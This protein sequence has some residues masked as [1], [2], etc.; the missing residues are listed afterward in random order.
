MTT[1]QGLL[2]AT[3]FYVGQVFGVRGKQEHANLQ[4]DQ[5]QFR[6]NNTG[7]YV[8]YTE[9]QVKSSQ[10]G[11]AQRKA[12][13]RQVQHYQVGG[14]KCVYSIIERYVSHIQ[15][16]GP[17]YRRPIAVLGGSPMY[18]VKPYGINA[19]GKLMKQMF[20]EAGIDMT[21]RKIT[22][23]SAR[24]TQVTTLLNSGHDNFDIKSRSGH[25]SNAMDAYKKPSAKRKL[26]MSAKLDVPQSV[27]KLQRREEPVVKSP[28]TSRS[29]S[30]AHRQQPTVKSPVT[31]PSSCVHRRKQST[32]ASPVT[33]PLSCAQGRKH[34]AIASPVTSPSKCV[35]QST[36][37][38][39]VPTTI[40]R[41]KVFV[42]DKTYIIP[43]T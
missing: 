17:F 11:L 6:R 12:A 21:D 3:F 26:E 28:V 20:T 22:N 23:H 39:R 41:L 9:R 25:R 5:F 16:C 18:S 27:S 35:D 7:C 32:V 24:V 13:P 8:E 36:C 40:K 14:D 30:V 34:S 42:G 33:S 15:P 10:G 43:L 29:P 1:S 4:A 31:T 37:E 19:L 38:I 2:C